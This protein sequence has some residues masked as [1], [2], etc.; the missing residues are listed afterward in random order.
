[1]DKP[2]NSYT[3]A[4]TMCDI[5]KNDMGIPETSKTAVKLNG[6]VKGY[7]NTD[8]VPAGFTATTKAT[9]LDGA[10]DG[11]ALNYYAV[12]GFKNLSADGD[13]MFATLQHSPTK[14]CQKDSGAWYNNR[15]GGQGDLTQVFKT[16]DGWVITTIHTFLAKVDSFVGTNKF[17][18]ATKAKATANV[19]IKR[20]SELPDYGTALEVDKKYIPTA[21]FAKGTM[22]LVTMSLKDTEKDNLTGMYQGK[23]EN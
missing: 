10:V 9:K 5:L 22:I 3:T 14:A 12:D 1:M 2:V 8:V 20:G 4:V 21:D 17:S 15:F 6:W 16:E 7:T 18:H 23:G 11:T 13:R 19:W